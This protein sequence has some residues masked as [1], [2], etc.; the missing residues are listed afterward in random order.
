VLLGVTALTCPSTLIFVPL[1]VGIAVAYGG[2]ALASRLRDAGL[3]ALLAVLVI[4]PW[5]LR[6]FNALGAW[7]PVRTGAGQLA[8]V[9]LVALGETI[10]PDNADD[11]PAIP[12]RESSARAAVW[13]AAGREGRRALEAWQLERLE[14]EIAAR[15]PGMNEAE[16]DATLMSEARH[17]AATHAL[18]LARLAIYKL[19]LF[20]RR[21]GT[22]GTWLILV[23]FIASLCMWRDRR[24]LGIAALLAA[25]AL[26]FAVFVAYFQRYR[27]PIEPLVVALAC[28]GAVSLARVLTAGIAARPRVPS[29]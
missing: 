18:P 29:V 15:A 5:S 26:P 25:Y 21:A 3:V 28:T 4:A 10:A 14:S 6:N 12:W 20:A 24:V 23:A 7:V 11:V 19:E 2:P 22:P 8:H 13:R 16:R 1:I 17:Y 9:G 27:S